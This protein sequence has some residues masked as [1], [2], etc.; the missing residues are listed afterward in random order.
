[1]KICHFGDYDPGYSR[2]RVFRKALLGAGVSVI[3]CCD[4]SKSAWRYF[5]L[6]R[7]LISLRVEYDVI[8]VGYSLSRM[9]VPLAKIFGGKP[10]VWD[11][12]F[13]LYD[14]WIL[15]R[16]LAKKGSVK[17]TYYFW[18]DKIACRFADGII[19][20]TE[21]N[22]NFFSGTFNIPRKK[23]TKIFVGTDEE[24]FH[25]REQRPDDTF[26]I[27]FHGNFLPFHGVEY[28]VR[29][30]K[31][32]ENENIV[33]NIIGSGQT[34]VENKALAES[35]GA[36]NIR[37]IPKVPYEELANRIAVA[38][39]SLGVFGD[40]E[41]VNRVIPNKI[42][43]AAA[44][45]VPVI[46]GESSAA[47]ELF[48]DGES[49]VFCRN[50]HAE[51]LAKK[52]L[53]LRDNKKLREHIAA[54]ALA[55]FREKASMETIGAEIFLYLKG[56]V[57]NK[58]VIY[59]AIF[60]KKDHLLRP[61]FISP[62]CDYVCFTD[63]NFSTFPW[64]VR[65]APRPLPD[66]TRSARMYKLLPHKFLPEYEI[67]IWVDGN[68]LIAKNLTELSEK[69]LSGVNL[70]VPD[71]ATSSFEPHDCVYDEVKT[72]IRLN[73]KGKFQDDTE[74]LRRQAE[75]YRKSG[76]PEHNGIAW[77]FLLLRKHN[78]SDV[79]Q[80]DEDWWRELEQWSKRD[81]MS[82]NYVAW[83]NHF[84]FAYLEGDPTKSAYFRRLSHRLSFY[85]QIHSYFLGAMKRIKKISNKYV[86]R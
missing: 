76:Y 83:K 60:G 40:I 37:F 52:I 15:D 49:V 59:T 3:E 23:F 69:Y 21:E 61:K 34:Y 80:F 79:V 36:K 32:L 58:I 9:V 28:I 10:V 82:F 12:L 30:A 68:V 18:L 5:R 14:S 13:S 77:T 20:D 38:D 75:Q 35:L 45:G 8:L 85:R 54:N 71:H 7:K 2:N 64:Q 41:R 31:I 72:L 74:I 65:K 1:M 70:V 6:A 29:A 33:W 63:Q 67:S 17:A 86:R 81:Q 39:I 48:A 27:H 44:S 57:K 50:M 11:P 56:M 84:K 51:D 25:P 55:V 53:L 26:T 43:E 16:K 66:A 19:L 42:F 24:V 62:D 78:E 73:E 46:T 22:I 47:K 4:A